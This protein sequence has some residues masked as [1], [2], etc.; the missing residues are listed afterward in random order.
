MFSTNALTSAT[1]KVNQQNSDKQKQADM[2][3]RW[4][5]ISKGGYG[6]DENV[7]RRQSDY[8]LGSSMGQKEFYDDPDMQQLRKLREQYAQGYDSEELGN[9]RQDARGQI[10]GAQQSAQR[11]LASKA[12]RG[13][14]GGARG[15]AMQG[16]AAQE[17]AKNVA[18]AERQMAVD[19]AN[20]K[21]QGAADLQDFIFRQKLGKM[22]T[23]A[24][25]MS[26]GSADY[27]AEKGVAA[28]SGGGK[29]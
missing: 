15:A 4:D 18:S 14:V 11:Q 21:R 23:A 2:M 17:G 26:T 8:N 19:S 10:A 27:A 12:A 9:I 6:V 25:F 13:G 24:G 16:A 1:S 7:L 5:A 22:G 28:N 20:M 29:K 3:S